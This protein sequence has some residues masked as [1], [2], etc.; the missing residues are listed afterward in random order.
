MS[1]FTRATF[2]KKT[3]G[4]SVES[5]LQGF[6]LYNPQNSSLY[7]FQVIYPQ[8]RVSSCT[9]VE[10]NRHIH[11]TGRG[12]P[13]YFFK[14]PRFGSLTPF[15]DPK[16][17]P[18]LTSSK[19]VPKNG[20]PVVKGLRPPPKADLDKNKTA[21]Y[22]PDEKSHMAWGTTTRIRQNKKMAYDIIY[23]FSEDFSG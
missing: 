2:K 9:G 10:D 20:F 16:S 14:V 6:P 4:F 18:I 19:I 15:R 17:L 8:I 1:L 12:A 22:V 23:F 5:C 7:Y 13:L 11:A 3:L 21:T